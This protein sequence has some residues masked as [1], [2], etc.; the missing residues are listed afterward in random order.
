[1]RIGIR[2]DGGANI[3]LGHIMRTLVL[4]KEL[5][6]ENDVIYI[7]RTDNELSFKDIGIKYKSGIEKVIKEGFEVEF[8]RENYVIE[9][10]K[11]IE[12][13]LLITDTYDVDDNYFY[14]TKDLFKRTAYID[15]M[16][17]HYFD[18]DFLINQNINAKDLDYKT[19]KGTNMLLGSKYVMLRE[20]FRNA[21]MKSIKEKVK[22][23][24]ITLGGADPN[25][26]TEK[27]LNFTRDTDYNFH[28]VIGPSFEFHEELNSYE[29]STVKLYYNANM[30]EIMQKCDLAISG[31]GS[32]LYE[33]A[34]C[35]VPVLGIILA[36]N[37]RCIAEKL[38]ELGII[39]NI[40]WYDD[41]KS[42]KFISDFNSLTLN[43]NIRKQMSEKSQHVIDGKGVG[44]LVKELNEKL[45]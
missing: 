4:A 40:G 16:N 3:G 42:D 38:D 25:H 30:Y 23:V 27:I 7:C 21:P 33:L 19:R 22:D 37:Q 29:N 6:K 32:T 17:K 31:C 20:E 15:D 34:S 12:I 39:K 43:Y 11:K 28:V 36:D 18:V 41:F 10:L 1:M 2:A 9:D 13:D 14:K 8:I 35:G 44:R 26:I 24:M 45:F 5:A